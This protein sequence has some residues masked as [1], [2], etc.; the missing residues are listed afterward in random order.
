MVEVLSRVPS[1]PKIPVKIHDTTDHIVTEDSHR[2]VLRTII[3]LS[4]LT[5]D[6]KP[7]ENFILLTTKSRTFKILELSADESERVLCWLIQRLK[8]IGCIYYEE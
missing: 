6:M 8:T 4:K 5:K 7:L 3:D 1:M 2:T